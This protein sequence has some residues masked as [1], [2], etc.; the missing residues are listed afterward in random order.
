[1]TTRRRST[2]RGLVLATSL[3]ALF[4]S[5]IAIV[6]Y[7]DRPP[8]GPSTDLWVYLAAGERLNAG[9]L[10][11]ALS[12]GDRPVAFLPPY[13]SVP[14][15]SPPPIAVLWR[16]LAVLGVPGM[17]LW[18]AACMVASGWLVIRM[19]RVARPLELPLVVAVAPFVALSGWAGNAD[20]LLIPLL[21]LTFSSHV[22]SA[23]AAATAVKL[24]PAVYL[25]LLAG[26]RRAQLL[27]ALLAGAAIGV[28]SLVGAG[29][30]SWTS[31]WHAMLSS[32]PTPQSV[33]GAL[34]VPP[35]L[36]AAICAVTA[37]VGSFILRSRP[38]A[39]FAFASV[40]VVLAT[41]ALLAHAYSVLAAP[42]AIGPVDEAGGPKSTSS[43]WI[44]TAID[45]TSLR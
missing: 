18:W 37:L 31:W 9:H 6:A 4:V 7:G 41:P 30:D 3:C 5:M 17:Y 39:A 38:R 10:L 14:L 40:M 34:Q 28:L 36:V 29:L 27:P 25:A 19:L 35:A 12:P 13:W 8:G 20:A 2:P 24:S 16:P 33:A 21:I 42:L 15:L 26:A 44:R 32:A 11:Y 1:M 23:I 22:G 45:E 43:D